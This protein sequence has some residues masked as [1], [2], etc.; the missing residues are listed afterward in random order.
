MSAEYDH[1]TL[2][3]SHVSDCIPSNVRV[4]SILLAVE[5]GMPSSLTRHSYALLAFV[6]S[7]PSYVISADRGV[8]C[9]RTVLFFK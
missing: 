8:A 6:S 3:L 2:I 7:M 5:L 1:V 9:Y 4:L